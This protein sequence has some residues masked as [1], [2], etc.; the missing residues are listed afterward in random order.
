MAYM[1][2]DEIT[3]VGFARIGGNVRISNKA[4]FYNPA[5]ILID[6][7]A[8]IDDFCI[9][10]A[11]AGGIRIG[12]FVH[13]GCYSSLIGEGP[14]VLEDF[15]G[16]SSRVS[17]YSS[18]DD[19]SGNFLCH[20]TIPSEYRNVHMGRVTLGKHVIVGAGSVILPD[21]MVEQGVVVGALSL[22]K[23]NCEEF[24]IYAGIPAKKMKDRSR[25]LLDLEV[26][27]LQRMAGQPENT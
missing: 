19:Y 4:S 24:G 14:I 11:G 13:V 22:V 10:S 1:T 20:P 17:I 25:T 21:V 7:F 16:I 12:R 18:N 27:C 2:D 8:R 3:A 26:K 9:L 15:S 23:E 5:N 6:D